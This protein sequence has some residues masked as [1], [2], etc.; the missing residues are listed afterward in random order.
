MNPAVVLLESHCA[1]RDRDSF[2]F[3]G[4]VGEIVAH[5]P[6]EVLPAL[7][8]VE[9]AVALGRHAA[10]FVAYEAA[11]GLDVAL[12]TQAACTPLVWFGLF[13]HRETVR[14]RALPA[15]GGDLSAYSLSAWEPSIDQRAYERAIDRVREYIAAGDTYQA[16]FTY[17]LR[18]AFH[19]D[20]RALYDD[21]CRAQGAAYCAY[22]AMGRYR[23]LSAS[24]E[25]FFSLRDGVLTARPMK[26]TRPRGRLPEEDEHLAAALHAS[27]KDRAENVMIVDLLRN[28]LGRVSQT[29]SVTTP[30][31]WDVER[32][33]TLWQLTSTV[34]SRVRADVGLAEVLGALFPCGSVTGAPKVRTMQILTDLEDS[35]RGIY[36]GSIGFVSPGP[37][38][39]FSVAI[40]TVWID[41]LTGLA[42][43]GVGGG[44]TWDS[45][46]AGEYDE[47]LVKARLLTA[48]RRTPARDIPVSTV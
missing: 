9:R 45:T 17:R 10:G 44:I 18:A 47:C 25:L 4:L 38:C 19:G 3:S 5:R 2:A 27:A 32:Y 42:E 36:T 6:C 31:L 26:G 39:R 37:E 15:A 34:T 21:L 48:A 35:P 24:P 14:A 41:S 8:E 16:N 22:L 13:T 1:E 23:V 29:G 40:R 12:Q 46:P 33:E 28:D 11:S 43:F 20:D 30:R 7:A